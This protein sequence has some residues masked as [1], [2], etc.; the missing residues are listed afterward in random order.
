[1][2]TEPFTKLGEMFGL[3]CDSGLALVQ[4]QSGP[5]DLA[6]FGAPG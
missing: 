4:N 5:F 3:N 2:N 1:M 6:K